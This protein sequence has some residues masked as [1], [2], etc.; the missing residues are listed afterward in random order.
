M[1]GICFLLLIIRRETDAAYADFLRGM[2]LSAPFSLPCNGTAG[3]NLLSLLGIEKT[4]KTLLF[5]VAS[6]KTAARALRESVSR[7]GIDMPGNGIALM[8]PVDSIG[9]ASSMKALT[10]DRN[11]ISGEVTDMEEKQSFPYALIIAISERG[12]AGLVMDAARSA[13]AGGGTVLHAR[14]AAGEDAETFLGVTLAAEK[15][16]LLLVVSRRDKTAVMRA[17]M[18]QAGI[19]TKAHTVLFSLP[20]E[21]V[22][23]LKSVQETNDA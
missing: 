18:E 10:A 5:A 6:Q 19:H 12:S 2:G 20:V 9:G 17:V 15:E 4:E 21:S 23:G 11:I 1:N 3:Q 14:G 16:M 13:G 22:A 7:M 8:L